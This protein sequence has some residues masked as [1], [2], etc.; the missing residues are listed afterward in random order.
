MLHNLY[1][2]HRPLHKV[3]LSFKGTAMNPEVESL[4]TT[5]W[6]PSGLPEELKIQRSLKSC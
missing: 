2:I 3:L 4:R 6:G 5:I 1:G